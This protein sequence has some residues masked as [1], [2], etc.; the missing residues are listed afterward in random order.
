MK[1]VLATVFTVACL[2]GCVPPV[3]Q[4][5]DKLVMVECTYDKLLVLHIHVPVPP[6][7]QDMEAFT[8]DFCASAPH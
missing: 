1:Y 4:E 5:E 7:V 6:E 2:T 8:K 3:E